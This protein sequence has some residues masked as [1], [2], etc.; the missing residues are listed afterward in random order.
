MILTAVRDG[1]TISLYFHPTSA[2]EELES[3]LLCRIGKPPWNR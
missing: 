2:H 1:Q 3:G